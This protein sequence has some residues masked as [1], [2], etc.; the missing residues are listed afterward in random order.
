MFVLSARAEKA[1]EVLKAGGYFREALE[2]AFRGG[3]KF[4]VRLRAKNG[5]VVP[6]FGYACRAELEKAGLIE[7][8]ECARSSCWPREHALKAEW[9][10]AL[11]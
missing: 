10:A 7:W 2:R 3:E 8:R 6:G 11:G 1:L 9:A 4:V 5:A